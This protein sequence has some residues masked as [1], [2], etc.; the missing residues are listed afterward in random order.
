MALYKLTQDTTSVIR[1]DAAGVKEAEAAGFVLE[2]ECDESYTVTKPGSR[3]G[4][5]PEAKTA[6][7][8]AEAPKAEPE[9]KE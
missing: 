5:K 6:E 2:G 8:P 3:P 9:A 1:T 4:G 7:K